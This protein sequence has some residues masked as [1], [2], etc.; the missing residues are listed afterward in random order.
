MTDGVC[1][2]RLVGPVI[3]IDSLTPQTAAALIGASCTLLV[4]QHSRMACL[5]VTESMFAMLA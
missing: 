5:R 1:L 3:C 4:L 2:I